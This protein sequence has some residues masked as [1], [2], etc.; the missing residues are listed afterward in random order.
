MINTIKAPRI[1][2]HHSPTTKNLQKTSEE[3]SDGPDRLKKQ[4]NDSKAKKITFQKTMLQQ[5]PTDQ[6]PLTRNEESTD[7]NHKDLVGVKDT[8]S[9]HQQMCRL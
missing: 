4:E 1:H 5:T 3:R 7:R 2:L 8:P 6:I 9:F